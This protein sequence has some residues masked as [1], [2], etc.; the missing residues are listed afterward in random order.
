M[1]CCISSKD[2]IIRYLSD[3]HPE[4]RKAGITAESLCGTSIWDYISGNRKEVRSLICERT[5]PGCV[6]AEMTIKGISSRWI[7]S[8]GPPQGYDGIVV[9]ATSI[10]YNLPQL[11]P[12]ECDVFGLL[13]N[14]FTSAGIAERLG[15]SSSTVDKHRVKIKQALELSHEHELQLASRQVENRDDIFFATQKNE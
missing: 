13:S 11:T 1:I 15:I 5:E 4:Y 9:V 7:L 14:G 6:E 12:R 3:V 8:V 10:P 2:G